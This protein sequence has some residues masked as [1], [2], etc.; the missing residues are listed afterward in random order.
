[1]I[2]RLHSYHDRT[3]RLGCSRR[4][5][6]N[7]CAPL[8]GGI[9]RRHW[10]ILLLLAVVVVLQSGCTRSFYRVQADREANYLV[11][12]KSVGT[13]WEVPDSFSIEPDPASRFSDSTDRDYPRLPA[14][15]PRLYEYELPELS[16]R[17]SGGEET[18]Q[19]LERL[20]SVSPEGPG[21]GVEL[22]PPPV[23]EQYVPRPPAG[24]PPIPSSEG[25]SSRGR[26]DDERERTEAGR[27]PVQQASYEPYPAVARLSDSTSGLTLRTKRSRRSLQRTASL[28]SEPKS[29]PELDPFE[30]FVKEQEAARYSVEGV[31]LPAVEKRYWE[32]VPPQFLALILDFESVRRE[33]VETYERE[34]PATLRDSSPRATLRDLFEL[35]LVNSRE[36]QRQKEILYEAALDVALERYAYA[37]KF[38]LRGTTVDTTYTH[39][40]ASGVTVNSLTVPSTFS[41]NKALATGGTLVGE[42]A[43]DILLTF[44]GP[45]GFAADVSSTLL[46]DIT[47]RVF[48]RD[49]RL[50]ALI[51][52]ERNLVYAA[53]DFTRYRKRFFLD[54]AEPYYQIL[55]AYRSIEIA[56]QSYF[57]QVLTLQRAMEE[58]EAEVKT[59][60]SM[61]DINQFERSTLDA[62]TRLIANCNVLQDRLDSMKITI[63]IPTETGINVDLRELEQLTLRD[64]I[65]VNRERASRWL[66]RLEKL[67]GAG[68]LNHSGILA[69][70]YSLAERL[71]YWLWQRGEV[72]DARKVFKD[73]VRF[74]LDAARQE[75]VSERSEFQQPA[76]EDATDA[77]AQVV[78]EPIIELW[79]QLDFLESQLVLI[80]RQIRYAEAM[81][82]SLDALDNPREK[83][84]SY[85]QQFEDKLDFDTLFGAAEEE[86]D[87]SEVE[88]SDEFISALGERATRL[89]TKAESLSQEL[90]TV[91]FGRRVQEVNLRETLEKTDELIEFA[92]A[93]LRQADGGLPPLDIS[94]DEA[95]VT[96]LVQRLDLMNERGFLADDWRAIKIAADELKSNLE[97]GASQT[98]G[99]DR[100]RPFSFSADN[101]NTRL[102]LSCDLP[103]NRKAERNF[104]R[105]AL[106]NY[107]ASLRN[108]MRIEDTIK[109]NV[110]SQL[111]DLAQ[112]RIR[113]PIFVSQAALAEE[114]V[115]NTQL[116]LIS[117]LET[118][119]LEL[120]NAYS[121]ARDSLGA[122]VD[123]RIGYIIERARFAFEL[124]TMMLDDAGYWPDINDPDYQPEPDTVY[125][126]NA[127]SAYGSFPSYLKVSREYQRM[128]YY[129]PPGIPTRQSRTPDEK[130]GS[131][132][133]PGG[134]GEGE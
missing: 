32:D 46:F 50:E 12:E 7:A 80:D 123:A 109:F 61:V 37:T 9:H 117:G 134:K 27:N 5:C 44:N 58:Q 60:P 101:A 28:G 10:A 98:I 26:Q 83:L 95:M 113:Y 122:M 43:N 72:S 119:A 4:R 11:R 68:D 65:E 87:G 42:F 78:E 107:N 67:R 63:G 14:A 115:L 47:Q 82:I 40:R 62:L 45:T 85:R 121:A 35:A 56:A 79:R 6:S 86:A 70:D 73:Y 124:E 13:P 130:T 102:R 127:G 71:S 128:L 106:I 88:L 59:A 2:S 49:I 126:S 110:R 31:K 29:E 133:A 55:R 36:Y 8:L 81:D 1:M 94:V 91:L 118:R 69:A 84:R 104:Y 103:L 18:Q 111:R 74:R 120:V 77:D 100:N 3:R 25:P 57:D 38:S 39:A 15:G 52:S 66:E 17:R 90:D 125:P 96:A 116:E 108:L 20:P 53:R 16:G 24:T 51:Q 64:R 33:Y 92:G 21:E 114:Q 89:L 54:V 105:R 75:M 34:P 93:V 19:R 41:G 48:Q 30:S 97:L 132:S 76:A 112:A 129:P 99:T 22:P 23:P 131:A